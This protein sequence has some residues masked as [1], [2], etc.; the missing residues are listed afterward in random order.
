[1]AIADFNQRFGGHGGDSDSG[2][3]DPGTRKPK[4]NASSPPTPPVHVATA[5]QKLRPDAE[6]HKT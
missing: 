1:M 4:R 5:A 2:A 3:K 6:Y